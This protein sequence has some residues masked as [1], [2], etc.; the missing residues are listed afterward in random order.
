MHNDELFKLKQEI[1]EWEHKFLHENKRRPSKSDINENQKIKGLYSRYRTIKQKSK[2]SPQGLDQDA[3]EKNEVKGTSNTSVKEEY[4]PAT[5]KGEL[6][7]TPQANGRVLSIFDYKLTPPVSS[8]LA[9]KSTM[10][11]GVVNDFSEH[12]LQN[13]PIKTNRRLSFTTPKKSSPLKPVETTPIS[14]INKFKQAADTNAPPYLK[15]DLQTPTFTRTR[16]LQD[17]STSPSPFKPHRSISFKL[18]ELYNTSVKEAEELADMKGMFEEETVVEVDSEKEDEDLS[19][20]ESIERKKKRKTQKRQTRRVKMAPRPVFESENLDHVDLH[21]KIHNLEQ[22]SI[23]NIHAYINSEDEESDND[24]IEASDQ[25][26]PVKKTRNPITANYKKLKIN[27][28]RS[29][30]FKQRMRR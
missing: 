10:C 11:D 1:K 30:R 23:S 18:S 14:L 13:T 19:T 20:N 8:P 12:S 4:I 9:A 28:P 27:D 25:G 5:P 7:P 17:F 2:S 6:G 26:S 29:K 24:V 22:E 16:S 21:S 15:H 3:K